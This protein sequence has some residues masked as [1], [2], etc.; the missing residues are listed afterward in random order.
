MAG[1]GDV[2]ISFEQHHGERPAGLHISNDIFRE[3]I[4]SEMNIDCRIDDS[5]G[6]GPHE[7]NEESDDKRPP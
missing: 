7:R 6:N 4:Q 2:A 3:H 1:D 5:D